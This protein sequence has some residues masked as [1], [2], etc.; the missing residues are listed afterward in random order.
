MNTGV[1]S[2][3]LLYEIVPTQEA[4]GAFKMLYFRRSKNEA[5]LSQS[6]IL[7]GYEIYGAGDLFKFSI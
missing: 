7:L 4:Q 2:L 6:L 5:S 1:G 3:S